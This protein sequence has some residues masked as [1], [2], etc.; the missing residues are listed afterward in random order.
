MAREQ[1]TGKDRL[2][3][4][5]DG[6]RQF[7]DREPDLDALICGHIHHAVISDF[8]GILYANC[9]DWVENCTAL[10]EEA[11]GS[12][13]LIR[14]VDESAQLLDNNKE[15]TYADSDTDGRLVSTG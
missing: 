12:L 10:A 15:T 7:L 11:D 3:P 4:V 8:D 1:R 9:G 6:V 13:R 14:W 5:V 2:A